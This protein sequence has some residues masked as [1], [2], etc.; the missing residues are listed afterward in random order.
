[1]ACTKVFVGSLP[2]GT[3]PSELRHL[4]ESYGIV[5]ECDIMNRCGFVHMKNAAM[6]ESA[7][8][9]LNAT[10]FKGQAIVVEAGRP[11]E[12]KDSLGQ[13]MVRGAFIGINRGGRVGA[14]CFTRS[15]GSGS[16]SGM[17]GSDD[18]FQGGV[19]FPGNRG[20]SQF[21]GNYGRG[22][23]RRGNLQSGRGGG[24]QS[25]TSG[26]GPMRNQSFKSS[27]PAP[28]PE[29]MSTAC[30]DSYEEGSR[31]FTYSG[32]RN[33]RASSN[34]FANN[35]WR[36]NSYTTTPK[37]NVPSQTDYDNA[38]IQS[39]WRSNSQNYGGRNFR[40]DNSSSSGFSGHA[41][42]SSNNSN[43]NSYGY[44]GTLSRGGGQKD[45][46]GF[47][48]PTNQSQQQFSNQSQHGSYERNGGNSADENVIY[49]HRSN[50][51]N[52]NV[53]MNR[54]GVNRFPGNR[55]GFSGNRGGGLGY[56][57]NSYQQQFPPLGSSRNYES[58][59]GSFRN[60]SHQNAP[61]RRF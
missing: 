21:R 12:K 44:K 33:G 9:A 54:G 51:S 45:R 7:I 27:R 42:N 49:H 37:A 50:A 26:A 23:A 43:F 16:H 32:N 56:G 46:R 58:R 48:L 60:T 52:M 5:V 39:E 1:M 18:C 17:S 53:N 29:Q 11:K 19:N 57:S 41:G 2:S 35:K 15:G 55:G 10:E 36:G 25:N 4:F 61:N 8:I 3:K 13:S 14:M 34:N 28:Y 47:A 24:N 31:S 20:G 59:G 22:G 30:L 40:N 6:A 38:P